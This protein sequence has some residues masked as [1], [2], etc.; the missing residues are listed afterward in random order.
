M[1][2]QEDDQ[3]LDRRESVQKMPVNKVL[4]YKNLEIRG[5]LVG[6]LVPHIAKTAEQLPFVLRH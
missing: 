4:S 6:Q 1:W 2:S 5:T 3:V